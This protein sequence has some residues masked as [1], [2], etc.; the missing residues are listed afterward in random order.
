VGCWVAVCAG[1]SF[2]LFDFLRC[3]LWDP[4]PPS[5]FFSLFSDRKL[6]DIFEY[7]L[8]ETEGSL[9]SCFDLLL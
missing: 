2:D 6:F 8:A 3:D 1:Y 9:F 7:S 4:R 5:S